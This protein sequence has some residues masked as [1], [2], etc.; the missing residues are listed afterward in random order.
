MGEKFQISVLREFP[1]SFEQPHGTLLCLFNQTHI[2][3]R[4]D[5]FHSFVTTNSVITALLLTCVSK[6]TGD[7]HGGIVVLLEG[8]VPCHV[9]R[10]SQNT[11]Q[12]GSTSL[13]SYQ[14]CVNLL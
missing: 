6:S 1:G 14:K 9:H 8:N 13:P 11:L 2:N 7:S 4:L 3:K 10:H 12:R 5:C